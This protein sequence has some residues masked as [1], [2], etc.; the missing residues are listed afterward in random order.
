MSEVQEDEETLSSRRGRADAMLDRGSHTTK[1]SDLCVIGKAYGHI[2][3]SLPFT[4]SDINFEFLLR[5]LRIECWAHGWIIEKT[6]LV[7]VS[8][9]PREQ[10]FGLRNRMTAEN[11]HLHY[12]S[13]FSWR[14]IKKIICPADPQKIC[15]FIR[16]RI[17]N[18]IYKH[19]GM[20]PWR[21]VMNVP[22]KLPSV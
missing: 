21:I 10:T 20:G 1:R 15:G 7:C 14:S 12:R 18:F 22:F 6:A 2:Q 8:Y 16:T 3:I 17:V 13:S 11:R 9:N 4:F 19:S 5:Y